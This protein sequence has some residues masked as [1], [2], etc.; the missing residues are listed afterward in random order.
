MAPGSLPSVSFKLRRLRSRSHFVT[1]D[2]LKFREIDT[3]SVFMSS[4]SSVLIQHPQL[5]TIY[6]SPFA[7]NPYATPATPSIQFYQNPQT[8]NTP[9]FFLPESQQP[10]NMP[11][12]PYKYP[13]HPLL[14]IY[15]LARVGISQNF[16]F[17][18]SIILLYFCE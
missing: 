11:Y 16:V 3:R 9:F 18:K 17:L 12:N 8:P 2:L 4:P 6:S 14:Q 13:R 7:H 5:Q 15:N 10:S 1:S